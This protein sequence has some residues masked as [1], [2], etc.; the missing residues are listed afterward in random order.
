MTEELR[1]VRGDYDGLALHQGSPMPDLLPTLVHKIP[2]M[3]SGLFMG[4]RIVVRLLMLG[5]ACDA[6]ILK[7]GVSPDAGNEIGLQIR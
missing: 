7:P 4:H 3:F 5:S 1:I 6:I 2:G